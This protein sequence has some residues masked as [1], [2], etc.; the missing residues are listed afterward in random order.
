ML[1]SATITPDSDCL[2]AVLDLLSGI[3]IDA[4]TYSLSGGGDAGETELESVHYLGGQDATALPRL[5]IGFNPDGRP[6]WLGEYL[7]GAAA[8]LPEGD[9]VNNEGGYGTVTFAPTATDPDDRVDIDMTY[10][11]DGDYG[12]DDDPDDIFEDLDID[13]SEAAR[14]PGGSIA[15]PIIAEFLS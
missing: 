3:G 14:D 15:A 13:L 10:R 8:D 6:Q 7:E 4:V 5:P 9:W 11:P 1:H 2:H 12:D